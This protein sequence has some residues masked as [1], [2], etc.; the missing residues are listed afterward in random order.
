[1]EVK[2]DVAFRQL[3]FKLHNELL[4]HLVDDRGGQWREGK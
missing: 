1:M 4:N 3:R 2:G